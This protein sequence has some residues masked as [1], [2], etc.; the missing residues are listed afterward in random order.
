MKN[1]YSIY[2]FLF[3]DADKTDSQ[4]ASEKSVTSNKKNRFLNRPDEKS[5]DAQIDGLIMKAESDS[6][7]SMK[8]RMSERYNTSLTLLF[9]QEEDLDLGIEDDL[10]EDEG[11]D[12]G[13]EGGEDE[14]NTEPE[15]P[16][17]SEVLK[18]KEPAKKENVP[19]I[20]ID[21]FTAQIIRLMQNK[22]SLLDIDAAIL[23]RA[24]NFIDT[25]YGDKFVTRFLDNIKDN[26]GLDYSEYKDADKEKFAVGAFGGSTGA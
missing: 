9:E 17:G 4:D 25:H 10:G 14:E 11:E 1:K 20:D 21:E 16:K 13:G 22:D 5:L 18:A 6:I 8:K 19:D 3:E 2:N 24:K 12:E 7:K 15:D 26:H 23:N